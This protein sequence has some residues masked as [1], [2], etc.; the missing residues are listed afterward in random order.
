MATSGDIS[1]ISPPSSSISNGQDPFGQLPPLPPPLRST[2]VL[3]PLTVFPVSNLSEDSYDYVFGGRRK[4]PPA[5]RT[6][7]TLKLTSPPVRLRPEDAHHRG[8]NVN[9]GGRFYRH[10][11][12]YAPKRT[13][14][15][16]NNSERNENRESRL[17]CH[18]EDEATLRQLLLEIVH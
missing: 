6:T 1:M 2:Q 4:T 10:S 7:T 16:G 12:S 9:N 17:R 11:F 13:R 15:H 18:G 8:G 5:T 14:Q 3:Q